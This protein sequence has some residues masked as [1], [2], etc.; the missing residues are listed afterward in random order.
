[1]VEPEKKLSFTIDSYADKVSAIL[2]LKHPGGNA[3]LSYKVKTTHP[4]RYLVRP[5]QGIV[6][7]GTSETIDIVL[8]EKDK[9]DF[10]KTFDR[11][12]TL[13][14]THFLVESCIIDEAFGK[15]YLEQ[16]QKF[17]NDHSPD[18]AK[19]SKDLSESL[20]AMWNKLRSG[21]DSR[22]FN[23]KLQ[24]R[25]VAPTLVEDTCENKNIKRDNTEHSKKVLYK[26]KPKGEKL[27][28][29]LE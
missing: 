24:A 3:Y 25:H 20:T 4:R 1:V 21:E 2:T 22:I 14:S 26:T 15:K 6:A 5:N 12:G 27:S 29:H 19:A 16:Y 17:V 7:P 10:L 28:L 9:Q 11:L 23:H 13:Y 8:V 18:G